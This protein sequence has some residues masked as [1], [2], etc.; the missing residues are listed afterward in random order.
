MTEY[1]GK[2]MPRYDGI[3]QVKGQTKFVDDFVLPGML[4]AKALRS[5]VHKGIIRSIDFSAAEKMP[6]VVGFVTAD[7]I[8]G[9]KLLR[10]MW[11]SA[12]SGRQVHPPTKARTSR[13]SWPWT[14]TPAGSPGKGQAGHRGARASL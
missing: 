11:R 10:R 8:P 9:A 1:V 6:G 4:Y 7:D 13:W 5:P 14:K 12:G 2:A 3:G